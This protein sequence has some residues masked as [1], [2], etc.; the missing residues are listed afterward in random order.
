[1]ERIQDEYRG[2]KNFYALAYDQDEVID[3]GMRGNDA[4]F[5][6]HGCS[7][8]LEVRKY[9]T[10]GDGWE[11][12]EVGMWALRDIKAGEELFYDYNFESFGVAA[13]SDELR[14]RCCC[15][16]PNCVGF[17]GR[18]AGEK[19]PK[20]LAAEMAA[21]AR[22]VRKGKKRKNKAVQAA[23]RTLSTAVLALEGAPSSSAGSTSAASIEVRTPSTSP[24]Q[25]IL[26]Q[27][28]SSPSGSTRKKRLS[29][30]ATVPVTTTINAKKARKSEPAP[31][32]TGTSTRRKRSSDADHLQVTARLSKRA[33][34][35]EPILPSIA[36]PARVK[37][38][39]TKKARKSEPLPVMQTPALTAL[40]AARQIAAKVKADRVQARK[41]LPKGWTLAVPGQEAR[42]P[43]VI[44]RRA[45][46]D[47]ASFGIVREGL[48]G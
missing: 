30:V 21:K 32:T 1:M 43:E 35:S 23:P 3:A 33:R 15:G 29:A 47:R 22:S 26:V 16:A 8:N 4:R 31:T 18:K 27:P 40:A 9:Q 24:L 44:G 37:V 19:S 14:T 11:E 5:I 48:Y 7:P 13:Q 38:K 10:L 46:R 6:N 28:D 41:G 25:T 17:L 36:E 20:E 34:K 2:H 42:K 39:V 12:Y 45:P